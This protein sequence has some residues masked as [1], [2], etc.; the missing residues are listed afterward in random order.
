[1]PQQHNV[2]SGLLRSKAA[3]VLTVVLLVQVIITYG[4]ARKEV[5]PPNRSLSEF[6]AHFGTWNLAQEGIVDKDTQDVLRADEVF[7]R[8]YVSSEF[9]VPANLFVAYFKTQR[10]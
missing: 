4:M 3:R 9:A 7:S 10:T 2:F 1:M 6:A 5:V 8:N